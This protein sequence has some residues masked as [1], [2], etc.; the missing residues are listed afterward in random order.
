M[1]YYVCF[2]QDGILPSRLLEKFDFVPS[3]PL[4]GQHRAPLK[5]KV[6]SVVRKPGARKDG[7]ILKGIAKYFAM[8]K[9]KMSE[10]IKGL[11][12]SLPESAETVA[13]MPKIPDLGGNSTRIVHLGSVEYKNPNY[14]NKECIFPSGYTLERNMKSVLSPKQK[15]WH[16][17]EI[18]PPSDKKSKMEFRVVVKEVP[19]LEGEEASD[20]FDEFLK[21]VGCPD[22]FLSKLGI[23]LLALNRKVVQ[24]AILSL[25]NA[26]MCDKVLPSL[27][28]KIESLSTLTEIISG[29][30]LLWEMEKCQLPPGVNAIPMEAH[31]PF[32]CQVCGEIE[33]DEDDFVLQCDRCKC[34]VHMSCYGVKEAPHGEL[35]LCD[36]C[37]VHPEDH[38]RPACALCPVSGG[39]MKRTTCN[40]WC[41]LACATWLPETA[42]VMDKKHLH[43]KGLV[44]GLNGIHKS[45][46]EAKCCICKQKYG[47]CLQCCAERP[48]CRRTFH[49]LCAR[50]KRCTHQVLL[51]SDDEDE[52][53]NGNQN[54]ECSKD[55]GSGSG[56]SKKYTKSRKRKNRPG[57][58]ISGFR[59]VVN[60]PQHSGQILAPRRSSEAESNAEI[61]PE[62]KRRTFAGKDVNSWLTLKHQVD[63]AAYIQPVGLSL[64]G[65]RP[66]KSTEPQNHCAVPDMINSKC[67][68]FEDDLLCTDDAPE[69]MVPGFL[70]I[71]APERKS[72]AEGRNILSTAENFANMNKTWKRSVI[73]GK[74]AIHGWGAFATRGFTK[75]E[76]VIEYVGELVRPSVAE[77]R[78][79]RLYDKLVGAGT[80]VFRLNTSY[81][82]DATRSGN[83]AHLLNHSCNPNCVSRTISGVSSS[84]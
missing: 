24:D 84:A 13:E 77:V 35:W 11:S 6:A 39:I 68:K 72:T 53:M 54:E 22:G 40:R 61:H 25:P 34:C 63:K 55:S 82:V 44:D 1:T 14:H 37:S 32:E 18:L 21:S 76:M 20:T 4:D 17:I 16:S 19:P 70:D 5:R 12:A 83:L 52:N 31:R 80:Y 45:R 28:K 41:H 23:R 36:V 58:R 29:D 62:K 8:G 69:E 33:E 59:L 7:K 78:E 73:P 49:F 60:C 50:N 2:L 38:Q 74:S 66:L 46:F 42:L 79:R 47:A 65:A 51:D 9:N 15:S 57:T 64:G 67:I 56:K 43:L 71:S 75:D 30:P 10:P 81:C 48:E 27:K 3:E 26:S